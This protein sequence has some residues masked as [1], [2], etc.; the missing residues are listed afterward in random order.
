MGSPFLSVIL[1]C[2]LV[3]EVAITSAEMFKATTS[4]MRNINIF[5]IFEFLI[6]SM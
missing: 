3:C 5:F 6:L 4:E 1:P 2:R